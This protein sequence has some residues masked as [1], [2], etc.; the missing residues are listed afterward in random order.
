MYTCNI[1][2]RRSVL[3]TCATLLLAASSS[4]WCQTESADETSQTS[5]EIPTAEKIE[6]I[7]VYGE[8]NF[9]QLRHEMYRVEEQFLDVFNSINTVPEFRFK[10][11]YETRLST[12]VRDHV[13]APRYFD[14]LEAASWRTSILDNI[15]MGLS[16]GVHEY[17]RQIQRKDVQ[18]VTE[19]LR[20]M[21]ESPEMREAYNELDRARYAY[22]QRRSERRK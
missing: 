12:R 13:C 21:S 2:P 17:D 11:G 14:T 10:C 1:S 20:R 15:D 18:L 5:N 9:I 4:A 16:I 22:E 6:E 7:V 8:M 3:A 19:M